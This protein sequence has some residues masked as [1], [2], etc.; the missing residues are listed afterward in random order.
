M[1]DIFHLVGFRPFDRMALKREERREA[2]HIPGTKRVLRAVAGKPQVSRRPWH[3][4]TRAVVK[5]SFVLSP[6]VLVN[7]WC[8]GD[9][10]CFGDAILCCFRYRGMHIMC[11]GK[12]DALFPDCSR[13]QTRVC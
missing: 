2:K 1:A 13:M 11:G 10:S 12:Y 9:H 8:L 3:V 7:G 5:I 4:V 6:Y